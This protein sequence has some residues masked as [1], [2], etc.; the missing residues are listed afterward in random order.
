M[1]YTDGDEIYANY[2]APKGNLMIN[3]VTIIL[4]VIKW[5][6]EYYTDGNEIYASY[7][8]QKVIWW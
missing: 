1:Y 6:S 2:D 5:I 3:Y 7:D 8:A 4:M